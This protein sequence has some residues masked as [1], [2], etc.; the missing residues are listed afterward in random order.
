MLKNPE[1]GY[2]VAA[3]LS[4]LVIVSA[5]CGITVLAFLT[6]ITLPENIRL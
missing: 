6:F 1:S 5:L 4:L 2:L 3:K